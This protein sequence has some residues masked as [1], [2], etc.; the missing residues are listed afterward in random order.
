MLAIPNLWDKK[1]GNKMF[2]QLI[3]FK[4][5][6]FVYFFARIF[7]QSASR[8]DRLCLVSRALFVCSPLF[9]PVKGQ[10]RQIA[11]KGGEIFHQRGSCCLC[12]SSCCIL[13]NLLNPVLFSSIKLQESFTE[14]TKV[15]KF[16][17]NYESQKHVGQCLLTDFC[18]SDLIVCWPH[19]IVC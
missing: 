13:S 1:T 16:Q 5:C 17:S 3:F 14:K 19:W 4:N 7:M 9:K 6:Q 18:N 15:W 11:G 12:L 10:F 2:C 8:G